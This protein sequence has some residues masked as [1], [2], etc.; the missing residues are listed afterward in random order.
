MVEVRAAAETCA[1]RYAGKKRCVRLVHAPSAEP[2]K[3]GVRAVDHIIRANIK[4]V[5]LFNDIRGVCIVVD[6]TEAGAVLGVVAIGF[7][8]EFEICLPGRVDS[9]SWYHVRLCTGPH[10]LSVSRWIK[11]LHRTR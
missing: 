8:E 9:G 10:E 1:G 5:P 2:S 11:N 6:D 7:G 4:I 3:K